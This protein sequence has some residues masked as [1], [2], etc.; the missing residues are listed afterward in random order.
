[1]PTD[2]DYEALQQAAI[3]TIDSR[4]MCFEQ[5]KAC[6]YMSSPGSDCIITEWPNGVVG[7]HRLFDR[8]VE[9]TWPDGRLDHY[10]EGDPAGLAVPYVLGNPDNVAGRHAPSVPG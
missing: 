2:P 10:H 1:M 5:G 7:T 8:T 3:A 6:V 4:R 9:R